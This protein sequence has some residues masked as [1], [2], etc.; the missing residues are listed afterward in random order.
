MKTAILAK[1]GDEKYF[2][3]VKDLEEISLNA[4]KD[5]VDVFSKQSDPSNMPPHDELMPIVK[6]YNITINKILDVMNKCLILLQAIKKEKVSIEEL[7]EDLL[8]E[9]KL[10]KSSKNIFIAKVKYLNDTVFKSLSKLMDE[11]K[12]IQVVA[13]TLEYLNT[14]CTVVY[15]MREKKLSDKP[16]YKPIIENKVPT[17][18]VQIDINKFGTTERFNFGLS[19]NELKETIKELN[20][21]L[22]EIESIKKELL[23]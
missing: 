3:D 6:E 19:E 1:Y 4:F 14:K 22:V 12:V 20:D 15:D 2:N 23:N 5:I 11:K 16:N 8:E 9:G 17:V 18:I 10:E 13:P 7:T 21:A